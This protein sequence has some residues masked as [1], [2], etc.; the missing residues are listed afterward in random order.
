MPAEGGGLKGRKRVDVDGEYIALT[1]SPQPGEPEFVS[2]A[3]FAERTDLR[4]QRWQ[5]SG[6]GCAALVSAS[7]AIIYTALEVN[8]FLQDAAV[9]CEWRGLGTW[10]GSE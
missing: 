3:T 6:P 4:P 7:G 1:D 9:G 10:D 5:G 8:L 2:V